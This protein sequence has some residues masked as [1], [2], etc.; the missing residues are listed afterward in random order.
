VI[1]SFLQVN[2]LV[3]EHRVARLTDF[4]VAT[5]LYNSSTAATTMTGSGVGGTVRWMAPELHE[6]RPEDGQCAR[7]SVGSDV[8]ALAITL[9][10]VCYSS[11]WNRFCSD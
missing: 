9:W 6:V 3:D 11:A 4:G 2:I 7:P 1:N 8:Y 5:V 10:E